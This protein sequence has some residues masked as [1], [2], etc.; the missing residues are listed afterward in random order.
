MEMVDEL[1]NRVC[2]LVCDY[3]EMVYRDLGVIVVRN[4][5]MV[6][7]TRLYIGHRLQ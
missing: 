6:F 2:K 7:P 1:T 5:M 4:F 3:F